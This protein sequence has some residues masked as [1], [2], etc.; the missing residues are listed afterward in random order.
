MVS[1][2]LTLESWKL[3]SLRRELESLTNFRLFVTFWGRNQLYLHLI[4]SIH[5][6]QANFQVFCIFSN[7]KHG[8]YCYVWTHEWQKSGK[9]SPW[10]LW[11]SVLLRCIPQLF[12]KVRE[13]VGESKWAFAWKYIVYWLAVS[14]TD[15][16]LHFENY[17]I[18]YKLSLA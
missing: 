3:R 10:Y 4:P 2:S 7:K 12:G 8:Y 16:L 1:N 17:Q 11:N 6:S 9:I 18:K 5:C 13:L 14:I 15:W